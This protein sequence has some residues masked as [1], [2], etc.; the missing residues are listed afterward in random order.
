MACENFTHEDF[1]FIFIIFF[2]R[3]H[4]LFGSVWSSMRKQKPFSRNR[5]LKSS[6]N[7]N[8]SSNVMN[9]NTISLASSAV[10]NMTSTTVAISGDYLGNDY[11]KMNN[12]NAFVQ[13]DRLSDGLNSITKSILQQRGV[14]GGQFDQHEDIPLRPLLLNGSQNQP[15][16]T[17]N[18][19]AQNNEWVDNAKIF[20]ELIWLFGH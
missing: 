3:N 18:S 19:Q 10:H 16:Q 15:N 6:T 13:R 8:N 12:S 5:M 1:Y 17:A 11:G 2:Q 20:R 7:N 4:T 9:N 14:S